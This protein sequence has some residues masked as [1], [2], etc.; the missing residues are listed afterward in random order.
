M[1]AGAGPGAYI[2]SVMELRQHQHGAAGI[3]RSGLFL[4]LY[5]ALAL[6]AVLISAGRHDV[7][8]YRLDGV[9]TP[10]RMLYSPLVGLGVGLLVVA[11]CRLATARHRWARRLHRDFRHVLGG[12]SGREILILA[13]S[14]ALGEELLFR[15]ALLPWLGLWPQAIIFALLHLGPGLR[16]LP[17]T[18]SALVMGLVFGFLYLALGDLGAAITA[19]FTI[20][21]LNLHYIVRVDL[22]PEPAAKAAESRDAEPANLPA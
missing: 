19:H 2:D 4:A 9:S 18:A 8:I 22:P 15:G 13:A 16:F 14:S 10:S 20:N 17:W 3:S 5:G 7:D 12:L 1:T 11:L 6:A 21:F